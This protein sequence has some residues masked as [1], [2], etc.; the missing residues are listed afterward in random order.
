[1]IVISIYIPTDYD[2]SKYSLFIM[3]S[4]VRRMNFMIYNGF[5]PK[6]YSD[7]VWNEF[8]NSH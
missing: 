8:K 5:Y 7:E 6:E 1:M 3:E 2:V 4:N